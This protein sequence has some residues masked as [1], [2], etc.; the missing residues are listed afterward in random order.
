MDRIAFWLG[1][2]AKLPLVTLALLLLAACQGSQVTQ[3]Q[4][5]SL[6]SLPAEK[7]ALVIAV[8]GDSVVAGSIL[9]PT[10]P[11]SVRP[12]PAVRFTRAPESVPLAEVIQY[13]STLQWRESAG[14]GDED[15]DLIS[16]GANES[17]NG[18]I[19]AEVG[20]CRIGHMDWAADD[21]SGRIIAKI[22]LKRG[23]FRQYKLWGPGTYYLFVGMDA[24]GRF[25]AIPI[26]ETSGGYAREAFP[27]FYSSNV[28]QQSALL[29]DRILS[30]GKAA[31][32]CLLREKFACWLPPDAHNPLPPPNAGASQLWVWIGKSCICSGYGCH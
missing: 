12:T 27:V 29:P 9:T 15:V 16:E 24:Q 26:R 31:A 10:C 13:A 1:C 28:T 21:R 30:M 14:Q 3:A 20:S 11:A 25:R 17:P 22:V 23:S 19:F 7:R 8:L 5:L 18:S 32:K 2:A 6:D 4:R